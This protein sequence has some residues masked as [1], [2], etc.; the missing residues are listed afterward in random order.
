[1]HGSLAQRAVDL[2]RYLSWGGQQMQ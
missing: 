2:A 1:V